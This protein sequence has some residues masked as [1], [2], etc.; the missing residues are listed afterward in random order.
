MNSKQEVKLNSY[1]ATEELG[2]NNAAL[3]ATNGAFQAAFNTFKDK[4]AAIVNTA[5]QKDVDLTGIAADKK[6][7]KQKLCRTTADMAGIIYAYASATA[8]NTLKQEV[9]LNFRDLMRTKDAQLAPRC[10]NIHDKG[11]ENV[12]TMTGYGITPAKLAALQTDINDYAAT[13]PKPRTA[14]TH[15]ATLNANLSTLFKEAD[16]ILIDQMDFL[17]VAFKAAN[18]DFVSDYQKTRAL[19]DAPTTTTQLKGKVTNQTNGTPVAGA[20]VTV[21]EAGKTAATTAAGRYTIKP[22]AIGTY[23]VTVTKSGFNNFQIT[24]VEVKLGQVNGL[25]IELT[26]T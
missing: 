6:A 15:R 12:D 10:Q 19:I 11:V 24:G 26:P 1:Q 2:D 4:I 5:Q 7:A 8:N 14:R 21:V 17:I 18:P 3:I 23:T 20:T 25:N 22:L 9:N 16:Q 13:T